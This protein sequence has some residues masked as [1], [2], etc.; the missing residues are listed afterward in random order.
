MG[1]SGC[2]TTALVGLCVSGCG[3]GCVGALGTCPLAD[4]GN[5]SPDPRPVE[6]GPPPPATTS[7][8]DG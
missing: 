6:V 5:R 4:D 7:A 8:I 2:L 1:A 3:A